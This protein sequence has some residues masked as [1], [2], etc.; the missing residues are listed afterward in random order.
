METQA[1]KCHAGKAKQSPS[2]GSQIPG[3]VK[4]LQRKQKTTHNLQAA[5]NKQQSFV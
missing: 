5:N 1:A 2:P 4:S 3:R